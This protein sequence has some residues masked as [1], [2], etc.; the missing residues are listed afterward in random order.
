MT[1]GEFLGAL[2]VERDAIFAAVGFECREIQNILV[3]PNFGIQFV[4]PLV[5]PVLLAFL[6]LDGSRALRFGGG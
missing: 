1:P 4:N 3:L 5:Q 2:A 6:L